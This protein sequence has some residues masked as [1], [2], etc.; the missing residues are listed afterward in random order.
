MSHACEVFGESEGLDTLY[1]YQG[2]RTL[3]W[4][5]GECLA[6]LPSPANVS[7]DHWLVVGI[8]RGIRRNQVG[9][10]AIFGRF[11]MVFPESSL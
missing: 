7:L 11:L 9:L 6:C 2:F 5:D 8:L 10:S 3:V 4:A 1:T